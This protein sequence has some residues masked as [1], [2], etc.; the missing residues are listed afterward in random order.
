M[1]PAASPNRCALLCYI[2]ICFGHLFLSTTSAPL[3]SILLVLQTMFRGPLC[4]ENI[5][6]KYHFVMITYGLTTLGLD[7]THAQIFVMLSMMTASMSKR[8]TN[9]AFVRP[10]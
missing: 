4:H 1:E 9:T 6:V 3:V 2:C 10:C 7:P 8:P 5:V